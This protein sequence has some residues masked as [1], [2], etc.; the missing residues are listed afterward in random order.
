MLSQLSSIGIERLGAILG[1]LAASPG[2]LLDLFTAR[3]GSAET[4]LGLTEAAI[5]QLRGTRK[6]LERQAHTLLDFLEERSGVVLW[7]G[8]PDYPEMLSVQHG[9]G[10][11][12]LLF[13][14][15][16]LALLTKPKAA[17]VNSHKTRRLEPHA[18]WVEITLALYEQ[19]GRRGYTLLTS[20]KLKHYNLP[21][22]KALKD[23][24]PCIEIL[25]TDLL[26][27]DREEPAQQDRLVVT[28]I[29]PRRELRAQAE[30]MQLRDRLLLAM[31]D[32]AIAVEVKKGGVIERESLAAIKRGRR[33]A[34]A[35]LAPYNSATEG[36]RTLLRNGAEPF[37]PD[38]TGN[39][40]DLLLDAAPAPRARPSEDTVARRQRLGQ[41]F[42]P[43]EVAALMWDMVDQ[44]LA[45]KKGK[46]EAF[47]AIDP[48]V[49]EGVFL[50]IALN[51]GWPADHL[52]GMDLDETLQPVWNQ[53]FA[54]H[55]EVGLH[56]ANGLLDH[57]WLG[58]VPE[59]FDVVIGNPPYG[60]DGL[61]SLDLLLTPPKTNDA[62]RQQS[63]FG[64][65]L[66]CEPEPDLWESKRE[67]LRQVGS[68]LEQLARALVR[69]YESWRLSRITVAEIEGEE[70][71]NGEAD[72]ASGTSLLPGIELG[73]GASRA[74]QIA[75][76][77]DID[78]LILR[79][80]A[81]LSA[82][83]VSVLKRLSTFPVEVLFAERF[84]QLCKPNGIVAVILPDGILASAKTQAF[85]NWILERAELKAVI[86]LP[87]DLFTGVGA[88]AKTCIVLLRKYTTSE[89]RDVLRLKEGS[90]SPCVL[91]PKVAQHPVLLTSQSFAPE[92]FP[93]SEY[94]E[95]IRRVWQ[96]MT[97]SRVKR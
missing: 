1:R 41:F 58:I 62:G 56:I 31:A 7:P 45:R 96:Q 26:R 4:E 9:N 10:L 88:K 13:C 27:W 93:F 68:A 21:R 40:L 75:E 50:R 84:L 11:P 34:V 2:L 19:L 67:A 22:F 95:H 61:R 94:L 52:M 23:H 25:D 60:G 44:L 6:A 92:E 28:G 90:N 12:P 63:L 39:S 24:V 16:D 76:E 83:E 42:T 38:P 48:T 72:L 20:N 14:I 15:G 64:E 33:V 59:Q 17:V 86:S 43:N 87:Q 85:R 49:G 73:R 97:K 35:R 18:R 89:R 77:F 82:K 29:P 46:P 8:H 3:S 32:L 51:R 80:G 69:A 81:P 66:A 36:N 70:E 57:P 74:R 54:D 47:F 5:K 78:Q 71:A 30:R 53:L 55:R 79:S 91:H 65:S 37:T